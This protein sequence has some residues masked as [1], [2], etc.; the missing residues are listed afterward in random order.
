MVR[1]PSGWLTDPAILLRAPLRVCTATVV[2]AA[3][4]GSGGG[5][6]GGQQGT[7]DGAELARY[8]LRG[9]VQSDDDSAA[10]LRRAR[11][12]VVGTT[13]APVFT[14]QEGRFEIPVPERAYSVRIT[15]P[16]FAPAHI[17]G[18]GDS[19]PSPIAVRL[20]R[21]AAI[22]G[23]VIDGSGAPVV[24]TRVTVR[25]IRDAA[26]GQ[27]PLTIT[28][29]TDDLGEFRV[30]SLPA[31]RYDIAVDPSGDHSPV[32]DTT[33]GPTRVVPAPGAGDAEPATFDLSP[34]AVEIRTA[35]ETSVTVLYDRRAS[36]YR[37]A[38][39]YAA[40]FEAG[41][42]QVTLNTVIGMP[43]GT[44]RVVF[45]R[46]TAVVAGR[47][48]DPTGRGVAG[49]IV[50]LNPLSGGA[51][52]TAASDTAGRYQLNAVPAGAYRLVANKRGFIDGQHGQQR[53]GQPGT[54]VTLRDRQR[55][56]RIDIGLRRGASIS[57]MVTDPDGEPIEGL[58]I[59]AW[60]LEYRNGRPI[61][62]AVGAVRRTDDRGR[63]RLHSLPAGTYYVVAADD[64]TASESMAAVTRAPKAFFPG[65][66]TV[67]QA[68]PVF[69]DVGIDAA[70][71]D[72]MFAAPATVRVSGLASDF[73]G[74]PLNRPV[75]LVGSS[76]SGFPAPAPQTAVMRGV[77]F[78]FPH[79]AP[80][81]YVIQGMQYWSDVPGMDAPNEFSAQPI[82][83][84]ETEVAGIQVRTTPGTAV[85]GRIRMENRG[86]PLSV[87]NW[88]TVRAADPDYEPASVLPRPWK[89]V[90]NPDLS[91]RMTGL[92]GPLRIA[93]TPAFPPT[94]WLKTASLDGVNVAEEPVL[95]GRRDDPNAFLDVV[96][97]DDG[98]EVSGRVINGRKE[99]VDHYVVAAFPVAAE[100]RH[101]GSRYIRIVPPDE[102]GQFQT[103]MLPP[104]DY[105]LVA[106]ESL[107]DEAIQDPE[108]VSGL[109]Q[110]GRRLSLAVGDRLTTEL[111]LARWRR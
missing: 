13:I 36:E 54:V 83:I 17:E 80:G 20:A 42:A 7:R 8:I 91:F 6:A 43:S 109:I 70:G 25:R 85:T 4:V 71:I 69:V 19:G 75:V 39:S 76:R 100:N 40:G 58:A 108:S 64:P 99:P 95:F 61:T 1:R 59:H 66:P 105:W 30:G 2:C 33:G 93:T 62:E 96:L 98:A 53:A 65:T 45:R 38:A 14:D 86:R 5:I 107:G 12:V 90:V 111:T 11:V 31:G 97:A 81:E 50:R 73:G 29:R 106:V 24:E 10:F 82:T 3:L 68:T 23:Y 52:M 34:T 110:A 102:R 57:G 32:V 37:A 18:A 46:G 79:V 48:T 41:Q 103:G 21:G 26:R 67:A 22:D 47:V 44:R 49:A 56:D 35:A 84:G 28:T 94:V 101:G 87:A 15:K 16:G 104:G 27:V 89:T 63:Y 72:M 78:E 51:P 74:N 77:T 88:L 92:V 9:Q 60:R 55:V